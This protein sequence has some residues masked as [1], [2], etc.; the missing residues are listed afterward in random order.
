MAGDRGMRYPEI[1]EGSTAPA[2]AALESSCGGGTGSTSGSAVIGVCA[3]SSRTCE[4]AM[5]QGTG[6]DFVSLI[7][8]LDECS[9]S[10]AA[11]TSLQS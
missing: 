9:K 10:K 3:S 5:S 7:H 4:V 1:I 6:R 11:A 2:R 8:I